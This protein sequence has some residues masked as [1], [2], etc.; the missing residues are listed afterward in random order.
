MEYTVNID[1][2]GLPLLSIF[3]IIKKI[4]IMWHDRGNYQYN[5]N[6]ITICKLSS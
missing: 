1:N 5:G 3:I 2:K 6:H 4:I